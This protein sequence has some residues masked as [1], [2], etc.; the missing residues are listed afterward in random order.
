MAMAGPDDVDGVVPQTDTADLNESAVR[1]G[2]PLLHV[3]RQ[4][5]A[6]EAV[7]VLTGELDLSVADL[8]RAAARDVLDGHPQR[9]AI[10]LTALTFCDCAGL[11]SLRWIRER[12][13]AAGVGFRMTNPDAFVRRVLS[14]VDAAD[15]IAAC[16]QTADPSAACAAE[17]SAAAPAA[18]PR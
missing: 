13:V 6:T 10:D 17:G 18:Q 3:R 2:P 8:L 12:A 16:E 1:T 15:L 5:L 9:I 14:L 7:L 11:R 4:Q